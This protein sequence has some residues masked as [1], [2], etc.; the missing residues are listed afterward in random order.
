MNCLLATLIL[1]LA[2]GSPADSPAKSGKVRMLAKHEP[3]YGCFIGAFIDL[4]PLLPTVYKD[5]DGRR[6]KLP[7]EFESVVGKPHAMYFYYHG[8]GKPLPTDWVKRLAGQGKLVQIALE[9]NQ[10]LDKVQDDEYLKTLADQ[11]RESG[12]RIFLRFASEMNAPWT[13]YSGKPQLYRQ[14][15]KL[16]HDVME[17]LAPNVAMVWCPA[18]EPKN[19]ITDYYPG[20]DAVDWVGVNFYNVTFHNLDFSRP[21]DNVDPRLQLRYVYKLYSDR[22]PIIICEYGATHYSMLEGARNA[23]FASQRIKKL[24]AALRTDFTRVKSVNYFN[25]NNIASVPGRDLQ[26]YS[27]TDDDDVLAAYRQAVASPYFLSCMPGETVFK[28][29]LT[30]RM[31]QLRQRE[32]VMVEVCTETGYIATKYCPESIVRSYPRGKQPRRNCPI[33]HL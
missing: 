4:D 1:A 32:K 8:Y 19:A 13:K 10:G 26:N 11:M 15:F 16:V 29:E 22:K 14:K 23:S 7:E 25:S 3:A 24:Y 28:P 30:P 21:G 6:H 17:R 27:L 5:Q 20:D 2:A 12:A 9:P 18:A 33:H 31:Y